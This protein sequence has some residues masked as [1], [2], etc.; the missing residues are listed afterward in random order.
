MRIAFEDLTRTL[1]TI[2][3]AR[4]METDRAELCARLF[5]ETDRDGVYTHGVNRFPRFVRMIDAGGIDVHATPTPSTLVGSLERWNGNRGPGNLNA[6]ACMGRAIEKAKESGIGCIALS[7]TT[8]W[9][10]GGSYGW[11]AANA[12]MIGIC[13]TN[14]LPNLPAWGDAVP[15]L[16]NNPLV[17]AVPRKSGHVV[18]DM[19]MSQFSYGA[20]T[21]HRKRGELLPVDG[22]FDTD[23]RLTRDPA[24]IERSMR[25]LP[26]GYWKGSGLSLVLDMVAAMMAGGL[27]THQIPPEPDREIG[28]CQLFLAMNAAAFPDAVGIGDAVVTSLGGVRYPGERVLRIREENLALGILVDEV[29]WAKVEALIAQTRGV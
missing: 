5:A 11:Q 19:A 8:H 4:G 13:W 23:G 20:L 6:Y 16:G 21:A 7:N 17:I 10:R 1:A 29:T 25:P 3:A 22:G 18:L 9:M 12:G 24:A 27:A 28:V 26:I 15:R 2:L 14:T